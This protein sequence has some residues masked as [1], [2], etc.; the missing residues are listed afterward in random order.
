M[1]LSLFLAHWIHVLAGM[2][3]LGTLFFFNFF[4]TPFL[5]KTQPEVRIEIFHKLVPLTLW[6][7]RWGGLITVLS[8]GPIYLHRLTSIGGA[9]FFGWRYGLAIS[10]GGL[11][12]TVMFVN[13]WFVMHPKQ[14][15]VIASAARVAQGG[16]PIPEA[17]TCGRRVVLVSRTNLLLSVPMLFFMV[18]ATHYPFM[19]LVAGVAPPAWFWIAVLVVVGAIEF[20]ALVGMQGAA[21][22]PLD[23]LAGTLCGGFIL[24]AAFYFL[25]RIVV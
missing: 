21:K 9:A 5:E 24:L 20:N 10:V 8:G 19:T 23:S 6:G 17:G 1:E 15:V 22:K 4:L 14:K 25:I 16:Q 2:I 13:G 11:L 18:A 7:F 12:G 3:W